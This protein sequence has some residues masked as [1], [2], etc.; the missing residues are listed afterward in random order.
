MEV[1]INSYHYFRVRR[2]ILIFIHIHIEEHSFRVC[3]ELPI[4]CTEISFCMSKSSLLVK[5][6]ERTNKIELLHPTNSWRSLKAGRDIFDILMAFTYVVLF[7]ERM[8]VLLRL[9]TSLLCSYH[10]RPYYTHLLQ[11]L[12][13]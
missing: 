6:E 8:I 4:Y 13:L 2:P 11:A 5:R 12:R 10:N 9:L 7:R 3:P 1:A